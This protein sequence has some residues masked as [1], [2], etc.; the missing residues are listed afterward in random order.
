MFTISTINKLKYG[1]ISLDQV[2]EDLLNLN[3]DLS[4]ASLYFYLCRNKYSQT[5]SDNVQFLHKT[6]FRGYHQLYCLNSQ[7]SSSDKRSFKYSMDKIVK[8]FDVSH[9]ENNRKAF[10]LSQ[11]PKLIKYYQKTKY[12]PLDEINLMIKEDWFEALNQ[13]IPYIPLSSI[14]KRFLC[15]RISG[16]Y[17][18]LV[19]NKYLEIVN[20]ILQYS[21]SKN[22][23]YQDYHQSKDFQ[24]K[25]RDIF[26][27]RTAFGDKTMANNIVD[28]AMI[29]M[30]NPEK[31]S[32]ILGFNINRY[33]P[34][35]DE[36]QKNI[37]L[38]FED[39][40]ESYYSMI[41]LITKKTIED[42]TEGII[43]NNQDTMMESIVNYSSFDVVFEYHRE[44]G[45]VQTFC[46]TRP[47]FNHLL[48]T[49][50]KPYTRNPLSIQCQSQIK[51]KI[52]IAKE[53]DFPDSQIMCDLYCQSNNI[54]FDAKNYMMNEIMKFFNEN[55]TE[56]IT[57]F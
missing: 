16:E 24:I 56:V 31:K 29:Q 8:Q 6:C 9:M 32:Y 26:I 30:T 10:I 49:K 33:F 44:N 28:R 35:H 47:E 1:L 43:I 20:K 11:D 52:K 22:F 50:K 25:G 45:K 41:S 3:F 55:S 46:F 39:G 42:N 23:V 40:I 2:W 13:V 37:N 18:P 27:I 53:L 38:L 19:E 54:E 4:T 14:A 51:E 15:V 17:W 57:L 5:M 12:V 7:T 34:T 48:E 21:S 36:I